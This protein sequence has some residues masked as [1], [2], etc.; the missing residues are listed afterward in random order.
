MSLNIKKCY[1]ANTDDQILFECWITC[2][3]AV[4]LKCVWVLHSYIRYIR[5]TTCF[6]HT[7]HFI[8]H[9]FLVSP[10]CRCIVIHY[11]PHFPCSVW[12]LHL[13]FLQQ[14]QLL[15]TPLFLDGYFWLVGFHCSESS[16]GT[17]V[18]HRTQY[19]ENTH[20]TMSVL[21]LCCEWSTTHM[22]WSTDKQ[23]RTELMG[24]SQ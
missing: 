11:S 8:R 2:S 17:E 7:G 20:Y 1:M 14:C 4:A 18:L 9:F 10:S 23:S 22:L 15:T 19:S 12:V 16:S 21:L 24:H 3:T 5:H 13:L 6:K